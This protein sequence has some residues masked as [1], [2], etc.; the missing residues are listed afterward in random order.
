MIK[1]RSRFR[2]V[3]ADSL[4][5]GRVVAAACLLFLMALMPVA[6]EEEGDFEEENTKRLLRG[7][8]PICVSY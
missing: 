3:K 8:F 5:S 2:H 1:F 4:K 7:A 6:A